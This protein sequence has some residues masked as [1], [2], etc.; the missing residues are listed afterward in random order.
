MKLSNAEHECRPWRIHELVPDFTL[1]DDWALPVQGGPE[2]FQALLDLAGSFDPSKAESRPTRFLWNL[3]D[4]LGAWFDLGEISTPSRARRPASCRSPAPRDLPARPA[5]PRPA[6]L[7]VGLQLR[8]AAL[9][10]PLPHRPRGRR[11]A[12]QQDRPR[13]RPPG[14]GRSGRGP[15]RGPDGRLR[16]A[17]R[18][19]RQGLHGPDQAVPVL[20]GVPGADAADGAGV[21]CARHV[22]QAFASASWSEV[23]I[24]TF[25]W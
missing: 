17:P 14:L 12:L 15:L 2:D 6:R 8:L 5:P 21:E 18:R 16:Q 22:I 3:R 11:R 25:E 20:G 9:R 19:L 24:L 13:C 1:E 7:R 23:E 4:R 10:P